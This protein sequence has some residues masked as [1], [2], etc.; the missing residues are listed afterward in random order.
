MS[1]AKGYARNGGSSQT[2][3]I[4]ETIAIGST[5]ANP[6]VFDLDDVAQPDSGPSIPYALSA[7]HLLA[8]QRAV[9]GGRGKPVTI[10]DLKKDVEWS[11]RTKKCLIMYQEV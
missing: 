1:G 11:L 9:A 2:I 3:S 7:D 5:K 6:I 10:A 8:A 4:S